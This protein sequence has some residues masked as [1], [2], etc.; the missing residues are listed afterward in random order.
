MCLSCY[1]ILRLGEDGGGDGDGGRISPGH[2][3]LI[4]HAP[5]DNISC[6][7]KSL[8]PFANCCLLCLA[9]GATHAETLEHVLLQCPFYE[10]ARS[11]NALAAMIESAPHHMF[12]F[13]RLQWR[14]P[15][16]KRLREFVGNVLIMRATWLSSQRLRGHKLALRWAQDHWP[17][18][19]RL[20]IECTHF[21][22]PGC[23]GTPRAFFEHCLHYI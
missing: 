23:I 21:L 7:G 14:W 3:S 19:H 22:A 13:C 17:Q 4:F 5:R 2:P 12:H 16:L 1:P 18:D 20:S 9:D 10:P 8:S 11:D 6:K 15:E